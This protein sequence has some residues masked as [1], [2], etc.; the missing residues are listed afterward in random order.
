VC[1]G[2]G[3]PGALRAA[4]GRDDE[5]GADHGHRTWQL[6]DFDGGSADCDATAVYNTTVFELRA[7]PLDP[8]L[9]PWNGSSGAIELVLAAPDTT[10]DCAVARVTVSDVA[11]TPVTSWTWYALPRTAPT[12]AGAAVCGVYGGDPATA[13]EGGYKGNLSGVATA[14]WAD[15]VMVTG[16]YNRFFNSAGVGSTVYGG[17]CFL[18]LVS[19]AVTPVTDPRYDARGFS[20]ASANPHV[21]DM[22]V[23]LPEMEQGHK[24]CTDVRDGFPTSK[25]WEEGCPDL[26]PVLVTGG[27][28]QSSTREVN[29]PLPHHYPS[30]ASW[31]DLDAPDDSANGAGSWLGVATFGGGAWRA[32]LSW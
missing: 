22:W 21:A 24:A 9:A 13:S 7:A 8:L 30:A 27:P 15:L 16:R 18:D 1:G 29:A 32:E 4:V 3:H 23:L 25:P 31:S 6:L 2:A 28:G 5:R 10:D 20:V 17:A 14:P 26:V 19:G 12:A 11:G